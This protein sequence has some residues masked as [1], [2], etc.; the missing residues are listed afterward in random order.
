[1]WVT[2]NA[3]VG[4]AE[5]TV[6]I[7]YARILRTFCGNPADISDRTALN[8]P[9]YTPQKHPDYRSERLAG[10]ADPAGFFGV[11]L[12]FTH[13]HSHS[14]PFTLPARKPT[15]ACRRVFISVLVTPM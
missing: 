5:G 9:P 12:P 10:E 15:H 7:L 8:L 11:I 14:F 1:M 2:Q 6:C 4:D 3:G 13:I